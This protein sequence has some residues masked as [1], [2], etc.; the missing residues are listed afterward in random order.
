MP[1]ALIPPCGHKVGHEMVLA[2][3][4]DCGCSMAMG[5]AAV[6][7]GPIIVL[8]TYQVLNIYCKGMSKKGT[9]RHFR[10]GKDQWLRT[11]LAA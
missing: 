2:P 8:G 6:S 10:R 7:S 9:G 11:S 4:L 5:T 3:P 1:G